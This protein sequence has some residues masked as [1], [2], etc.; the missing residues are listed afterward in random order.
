M[1][2]IPNEEW[3]RLAMEK[4]EEV[5]R[6]RT[7]L[8]GAEASV[9]EWRALRDIAERRVAELEGALRAMTEWFWGVQTEDAVESYE[10]VGQEFYEDT[11]M[12]RPGKSYPV[13]M[14]APDDEV[15][16]STWDAW[17]KKKRDALE[18]KARAALSLPPDA[19]T[20]GRGIRACPDCGSTY[21]NRDGAKALDEAK[22]DGYA[23]GVEDAARIADRNDMSAWGIARE[24]RALAPPATEGATKE[25]P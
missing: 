12:M 25:E 8:A 2:T 6:L 13:E 5:D 11:G 3:F 24:I 14:Y 21:F 20:V 9:D 19:P 7:R 1:S 4:G 10:R 22:R 23:Q 16:R 15:R 17:V 18:A